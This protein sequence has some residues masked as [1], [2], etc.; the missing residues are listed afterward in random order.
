MSAPTRHSISTFETRSPEPKQRPGRRRRSA[1]RRRR[2][3]RR[4]VFLVVVALLSIFMVVTGIS[5]AGALTNPG[6]GTSISARF[7]EWARDH[8]GGGIVRWGENVWYS[9]HQPPVGGKPPKGAIALPHGQ[10]ATNTIGSAPSP[11]PVADPAVRHSRHSGRGSMVT[12]G[13]AGRRDPRHLRDHVAP[14]SH[15]YQ[16]RGRG[17]VDGYQIAPGHVVLGE[18][19][20]RRGAL[21]EHCSHST[22]RGHQPRG[23][24]QR[25]FPHAGRQWR[26]LH[27]R[28]GGC[29]SPGRS[30]V[31]RDLQ[32]GSATVG[33]WGQNGLSLTPDVVAVRQN[34]DLLVNGGQPVPGLNASDTTQWGLT[35]G[36]QIYVWR[37]GVGVTATGALVYVGGP[38]LNI[39]TLADLLVRA[40]AV[41]A[42]ELDINTDWVNLATTLRPRRTV[43]RRRPTGPTCSRPWPGPRPG[44]SSRLGRGTSLPCRQWDDSARDGKTQ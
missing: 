38:G 2:T 27:R 13:E 41:Q 24:V 43:R 4:R 36:N 10:V 1:K 23:R 17:G 6:L 21:H 31:V 35:L 25:R 22:G 28:Q 11:G 14:G 34:L 32:N 19:H 18:L 16:R 20:P 15:P 8:G 29:A 42:M 37:S 30:G 39:T 12:G 7:T 44:T 3:W 33:A 40:G 5:L 26:L 9:H